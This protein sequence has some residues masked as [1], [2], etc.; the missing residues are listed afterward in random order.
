MHSQNEFHIAKISTL[1]T[2][3]MNFKLPAKLDTYGI[4]N[5]WVFLMVYPQIQTTL[6]FFFYHNLPRFTPLSPF[7]LFSSIF[8]ETWEEGSSQDSTN[9]L[10]YFLNILITNWKVLSSTFNFLCIYLYKWC[11]IEPILMEWNSIHEKIPILWW[12]KFHP[13]NVIY[14]MISS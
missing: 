1:W 8:F 13:R 2:T 3:Q 9:P 12:N 14:N 11:E 10:N 6:A 4:W 7:F 5:V